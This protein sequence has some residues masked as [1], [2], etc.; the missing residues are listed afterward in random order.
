MDALMSMTCHRSFLVFCEVTIFSLRPDLL[1]VMHPSLGVILV[2]EVKTPGE[3]VFTSKHIAGQIHDYLKGMARLGHSTPFVVLCS[4]ENMVFARLTG[5]DIIEHN[6]HAIVDKS[7]EVLRS[8]S[9]KH[10]ASIAAVELKPIT[11]PADNGIQNEDANEPWIPDSPKPPEPGEDEDTATAND[12]DNDQTP[13]IA[14]SQVFCRA[15][16]FKAMILAIECGIQSLNTVDEALRNFLPPQGEQLAVDLPFVA[17][18]SFKWKRCTTP[19]RYDL[20]SSNR[21]KRFYLL[22][23]LGRG[24]CGKVF[25]ACDVFGRTCA[26]KFYLKISQDWKQQGMQSSEEQAEEMA[27]T[28]LKRWTD[29]YPKFEL[30]SHKLRLN[31]HIVLKTPYFTSVPVKKR[32]EMDVLRQVKSLLEEFQSKGLYYNEVRWRHVGCSKDDNGKLVVTMLGLGSL[33]PRDD[34]TPK[35]YVRNHMT[36]LIRIVDETRVQKLLESL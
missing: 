1:V 15:N 19:L 8:A 30:C 32:L 5:T 4:Y 23:E 28:E 36:L 6:Y 10:E 34:N 22:A 25:L 11:S 24:Q 18:T 13:V 31:H 9:G 2:V 17:E 20:S 29:L 35:D 7:K 27:E 12:D 33:T 21:C 26:L 3:K 14:Y 16:V